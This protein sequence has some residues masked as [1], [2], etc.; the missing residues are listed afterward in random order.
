MRNPIAVPTAR[1]RQSL[2]LLLRRPRSQLSHRCL[3]QPSHRRR[4]RRPNKRMSNPPKRRSLGIEPPKRR[5][6]ACTALVL[7]LVR[8]KKKKM[9]S[10]NK[11]N[12]HFQIVI[13]TRSVVQHSMVCNLH[14]KDPEFSDLSMS[15]AVS[16]ACVGHTSCKDW[17]TAFGSCGTRSK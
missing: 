7:G 11:C 12:F 5:R 6:L 17:R 4:L 3:L 8:S 10:E 2:F 14:D 9:K 1:R 13:Q 16:C 15:V